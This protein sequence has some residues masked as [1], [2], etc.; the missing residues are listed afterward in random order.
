MREGQ[1]NLQDQQERAAA[2]VM[3]ASADLDKQRERRDSQE[4]ATPNSDKDAHHRANSGLF[5]G[6]QPPLKDFPP[7]GSSPILNLTKGAGL[8]G[9]SDSPISEHAND[10]GRGVEEIGSDLEDEIAAKKARKD[11]GRRGQ[12]R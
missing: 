7:A 2:A 12:G 4:A 3:A 8:R 1:R 5:P 9:S 11:V 10:S 6:G